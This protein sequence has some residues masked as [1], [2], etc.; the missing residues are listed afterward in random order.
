MPPL[1]PVAHFTRVNVI[2]KVIDN[3]RLGIEIIALGVGTH[4]LPDMA[5]GCAR[6]KPV[7]SKPSVRV[8]GNHRGRVGYK[9]KALVIVKIHARGLGSVQIDNFHF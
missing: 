7:A 8:N 3:A 9:S 6:I 2:H 5:N 4:K 1:N